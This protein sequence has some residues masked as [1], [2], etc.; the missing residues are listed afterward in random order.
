MIYI[1][2][3]KLFLDSVKENS[4]KLTKSQ[5]LVTDYIVNNIKEATYKTASNIA[6]EIGVSESTVVRVASTLGYKNF[7][8]LQSSIQNEFISSQPSERLQSASDKIN[9]TDAFSQTMNIEMTNIQQ[10]ANQIH[11]DE[12]DTFIKLIGEASHVY[13]IGF[14][15]SIAD[16]YYLGFALNRMLDNVTPITSTGIDLDRCLKNADENCVV[17]VF[18]FPRYT[19]LTIDYVNLLK[20]YNQTTIVLITDSIKSPLINVSDYFFLISVDSLSP[21]YSHV[22]SIAFIS[23]LLASI[24]QHYSSRVMENLNRDEGDLVKKDIFYM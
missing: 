11:L 5:R 21:H 19:N 8:H 15:S 14:R 23:A 2:N 6:K 3:N 1:S 24:G 13:T 20:K 9:K 16:A 10:T 7:S 4:V 18:S 12:F 17:I 22:S